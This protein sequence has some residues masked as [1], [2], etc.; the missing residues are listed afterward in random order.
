MRMWVSYIAREHEKSE[1]VENMKE[2]YR[3][4]RKKESNKQGFFP[5]VGLFSWYPAGFYQ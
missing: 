4:I 5:L 3:G 2:T 1:W